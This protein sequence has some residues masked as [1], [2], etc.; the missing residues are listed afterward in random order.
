MKR[1]I[2][3]FGCM[4]CCF[5]LVS[6]SFNPIIA[7]KNIIETKEEIE[8]NE[9]DCDC[10]NKNNRNYPILCLLLTPLWIIVA[11]ITAMIT[12]IMNPPFIYFAI[13]RLGT[14]LG[15]WWG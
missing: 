9:E 14:D 2:L 5:F 8:I 10:V 3:M 4:I 1:N 11:I 15:C 7:D 6:I 13:A 12:S